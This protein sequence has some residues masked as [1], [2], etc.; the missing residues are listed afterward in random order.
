MSVMLREP[1][2][3]RLLFVSVAGNLFSAALIGAH[4]LHPARAA[5]GPD[6]VVERIARDLPPA[7]AE[8]F[9]TVLAR[10]RAGHD[11]ARDRMN[12]AQAELSRS[13]GHSPYDEAT[14]RT[15]MAALQQRRAESSG[16]FG[17]ALLVAIGTLS[18]EGRAR[19]ADAADRHIKR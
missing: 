18:P 19:L 2:R 5:S 17:E 13:I 15:R 4:L 9:R 1:W 6:G 14:V 16:K 8:R 3:T 12:K 10:E 11:E 7:D